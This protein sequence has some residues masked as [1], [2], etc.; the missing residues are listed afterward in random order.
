MAAWFAAALSPFFAECFKFIKK[1]HAASQKLC[2]FFGQADAA[3][4]L[5]EKAHTQILFQI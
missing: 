3:G 4:R 1:R 2:A 5:F